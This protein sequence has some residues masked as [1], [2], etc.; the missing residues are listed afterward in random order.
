MGPGEFYYP[1]L[2]CYISFFPPIIRFNIDK[3]TILVSHLT[4]EVELNEITVGS[5]GVATLDFLSP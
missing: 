3:I 1:V 5:V 4:V 2:I